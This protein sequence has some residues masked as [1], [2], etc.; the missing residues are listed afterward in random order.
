MSRAKSGSTWT[1]ADQT[2]L[3]C[4]DL[5]RQP[6]LSRMETYS[7]GRT[8][9]AESSPRWKKELNVVYLAIPGVGIHSPQGSRR[10]SY[11]DR[12]T[13]PHWGPGKSTQVPCLCSPSPTRHT[14]WGR[15]TP[16]GARQSPTSPVTKE[17]LK[18]TKYLS[19]QESSRV[20][21]SWRQDSWTLNS[22]WHT[23]P[24]IISWVVLWTNEKIVL[25]ECVTFL[26]LEAAL[27]PPPSSSHLPHWTRTWVV[28]FKHSL[29]KSVFFSLGIPTQ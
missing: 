23:K 21:R 25:A 17:T 2:L 16:G 27:S 28:T 19:H 4:V 6:T 14:P 24:V 1:Q 10:T 20:R 13:L 9:G 15:R 7:W 12:R 26:A 5:Q 11:W 3:P 22:T 8:T 29:L 18:K